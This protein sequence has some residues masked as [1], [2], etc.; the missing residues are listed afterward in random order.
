MTQ[1]SPALIVT[2]VQAANWSGRPVS[3]SP[4]VPVTRVGTNL[5]SSEILG[6]SRQGRANRTFPPPA[7][8]LTRGIVISVIWTGRTDGVNLNSRAD[9]RIG[10]N[11]SVDFQP[12][13]MP[14]RS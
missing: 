9:V 8:G 10:A 13:T 4:S 14:P 12:V 5:P 6:P 3:R 7:S 1:L 2:S 11:R